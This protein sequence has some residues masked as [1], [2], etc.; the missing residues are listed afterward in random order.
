M[1]CYNVISLIYLYIVYN[2]TKGEGE[3]MDVTTIRYCIRML[4]ALNYYIS[5]PLCL[6]ILAVSLAC[7]FLSG[8]VVILALYN[9]ICLIYLYIVYNC[10]KG[11][12][13]G[14]DVTTIRYC[15]RMLLALNYYVSFP[16]C[17]LIL[18]VSLACF[19]LS[20]VVVNVIISI[21]ATVPCLEIYLKVNP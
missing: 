13:E 7:F 1:G 5:F 2:C 6:L 9:V 12:G 15:I 18:V 4:L 20:G 21:I 3:G 14:M 11:E 17:L 10:T 8:V 16:L 19:F